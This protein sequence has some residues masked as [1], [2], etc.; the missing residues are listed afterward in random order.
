MFKMLLLAYLGLI[1]GAGGMYLYKS[2]NSP[3]PVISSPSAEDLKRLNWVNQD[4]NLQNN[5]RFKNHRLELAD[6]AAEGGL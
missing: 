4:P 5:S 2:K 1:L 6:L 3:K